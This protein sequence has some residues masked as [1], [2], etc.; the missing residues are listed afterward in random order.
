MDGQTWG[1]VGGIAG[2]VLG[3]LGGAVGTYFGV[4]NTNGPAEHMLMIRAAVLG[5]VGVATFVASLLLIPAPWNALAWGVY[6]PLLLLFIFWVNKKQAL[7]R[8]EEGRTPS[9]FDGSTVSRP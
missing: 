9:G 2:S 5:W 6:L 1:L 8:A 7:V 3:V 4:K